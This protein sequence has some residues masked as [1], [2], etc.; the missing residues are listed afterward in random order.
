MRIS[1]SAVV[2][3]TPNAADIYSSLDFCEFDMYN[4]PRAAPHLETLANPLLEEKSCS[5]SFF[6][7]SIVDSHNT[8][9]LNLLIEV[10]FLVMRDMNGD[11]VTK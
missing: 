5:S 1:T 2:T 11:R 9:I 6:L 10:I 3:V 8:H 4:L 7:M